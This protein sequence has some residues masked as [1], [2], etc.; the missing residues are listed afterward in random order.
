MSQP[1]DSPLYTAQAEPL[2]YQPSFESL[3]ED[4]AQTTHDL[5]E[6]LHKIRETVHRDEGHAYRSV[7]AKSHGLLHAELQ[8][9]DGL[10]ARLAQG[11]F[12]RAGT[13][14]VVMRFSTA[15][16]DL[17]DD[18]VSTPRGLAIKVIGVQGERL[19]G[20]EGDVTQ[21]FLFTNGP[22]FAA[23]TARK[24]LSSLKL[25][26]AT[27]DRAPGLK[28][29]L[30]AALRGLETLVE[31]AG[32]ESGTLKALGGHP[33]TNVLGETYYTQVPLLY[34]PYMAKLSLAPVSP[35]LMALKDA[36]VDLHDRPNG[37]RDAVLAHFAEHG[38]VWALR[39]QLCT[40]IEA[41]PLE[42]ASIAWPEDQSPYV[43]VA[44]L[45][46]PPQTAW[47]VARSAAVDE[48]MAFSPW[49]G[50]A[51]HRPLGSIMRVRKAV[52]DLAAAYRSEH[53]AIPVQEPR[54]VP[55]W[56]E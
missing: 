42:D 26:A 2:R 19:P 38:G 48:G 7:H 20:S 21:D 4:E 28:R 17:L 6:A 29:V 16:G 27:T 47:S 23:P 12:A 45:V 33:L 24:F 44:Q 14:P 32:G 41:M 50:L 3:E 1:N 39:A 43:T 56:A 11:L 35:E 51:A 49:H 5:D 18:H 9:S 25:L 55:D 36:V 15:P 31:K 52:Y 53:N 22:V 30:S 46:A 37:L 54:Q 13:L 10:P 8:V 40:D 34:G